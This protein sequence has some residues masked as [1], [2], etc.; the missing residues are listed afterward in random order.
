[1]RPLLRLRQF[2][3]PRIWNLLIAYVALLAGLFFQLLVPRILQVAIDDGLTAGDNSVLTRAA[4][5]LVLASIGLAICSHFRVYL[6]QAFSEMVAFDIRQ[7]L[8]AQLQRLPAGYYDAHQTG[9]LMARATEDV[10]NIRMLIFTGLRT[11]V[12]FFGML[13]ASSILLFRIDSTLAMVSMAAMPFLLIASAKYE[14]GVRPL[15]VSIQR[16]FGSMTT[17][18][19]ENISGAR[20]VRAYAQEREETARFT[21]E[22]DALRD[23]NIKASRYWALANSVLF[24]AAGFGTVVVIW[25]GGRRVVSGDLTVGSM[26]AFSAYL[27]LFADPVRWLGMVANRLARASAST[28]RIFDVLDTEP[29]IADSPEAKPLIV[30]NGEV[31]FEHVGLTYAGQTNPALEDISL[32][33]RGGERIAIVGKTG[34]G[35]SSLLAL[36]SR[37]HDPTVG[38]IT[39]DGQEI[40]GV[41]LDSLR[42][43][44][45]SVTQEPFLFSLTIGENIAFGR[46]DASSDE[47][48]AA[49]RAARIHDFIV[50]LPDQYDTEV[51][52]RGVTLSGGQKQRVAIARTLLQNPRILVLDDATSAVDPETESEVRAALANLMEART[53]FVIAQRLESV[54]GADQIIVM[55]SGAIVDQGTHDE[56]VARDGIYQ[57]IWDI[58]SRGKQPDDE[59]GLDHDR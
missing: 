1:M 26:V 23:Q 37:L 12:L 32:V 59:F 50:T 9:Q 40:R 4:I 5:Y 46:P 30:T 8:Y 24:L 58:Q 17:A 3:R 6:F 31:R 33:A 14:A 20:L 41:T 16:Q 18:L 56:L 22:V 43:A 11:I 44:V 34:S 57:R 10:N 49:A 52:E 42:A 39:I 28:A 13:I 54:R 19:Q 2:I 21:A 38:R 55:D 51:G 36:L 27:T 7:A 15:F 53:T 45:G 29:A 25:L 35:K 48:I 47:I